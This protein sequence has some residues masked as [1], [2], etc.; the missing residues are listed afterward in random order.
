M[1]FKRQTLQN[2][3][4]T[5]IKASNPMNSTAR[6]GTGGVAGGGLMYFFFVFF[7]PTASGE[8]RKRVN[9]REKDGGVIKRTSRDHQGH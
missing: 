6:R 8:A 5:R 4:L 7:S 3:P 2:V 9:S 1:R